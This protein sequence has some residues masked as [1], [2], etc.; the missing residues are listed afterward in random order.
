[1]RSDP[2]HPIS[3][4]AG[5]PRRL[6]WPVPELAALFSGMGP[7]ASVLKIGV[8]IGLVMTAVAYI[9]FA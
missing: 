8:L 7:L 6:G 3:L 4:R 5:C 1:M 9:S 2:I